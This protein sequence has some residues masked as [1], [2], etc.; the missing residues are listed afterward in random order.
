MPLAQTPRA[1]GA[2]TRLLNDHLSRR[3]EVSIAIGRPE[4]ATTSGTNPKINLFLYETAFE[5]SMH[6]VSLEEGQPPPLWLSLKYL[7]TAFDDMGF[8]DTADAHELLGRAISA[9]QEV[10]Y[11]PLHSLL[12][13]GV[14][15]ALQ[16]NPEPLKI[17]F[18]SANAELLSSL[19]QGTDEKY[20]LSIAFQVR[21]ILIAPAVPPDYALLVGVDYT[22]D[23]AA[24]IGMD[25]FSLDV[26]P[27]LGPVLKSV[28]PTRFEWDGT[29]ELTGTDLHL[30]NLDV[31]L[32]DVPVP[33]IAQRPDK[34]TCRVDLSV[35][36]GQTLSA[37]AL[38][39]FARQNLASG[40]SRYSEPIVG[41]LL[42][43]VATV[44]GGPFVADI[45]GNLSGP[46]TITGQ[47]LG[48][49]SDDVIVAFYRDG[50]V[51]LSI[52]IVTTNATQTSLTLAITTASPLAPG[53]YRVIVR[54]NGQQAKNSPSLTLA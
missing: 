44:A 3:T 1:I 6:N 50:A 17:T 29:F 8:S 13:A 16:D 54:V 28:S 38:P 5:G 51:A 27:S 39:I 52:D 26:I 49:S 22:Q 32:R 30:A 4:A 46:L 7:V 37:G 35:A 53:D 18:D 19:M 24:V 9:L 14:L 23:P 48:S 12:P 41:Y 15:E 25:G 36:P 21:P 10:C 31:L 45:D 34:L 40:R 20:R 33:V 2:V 47:L 43:S 42:P 11:L